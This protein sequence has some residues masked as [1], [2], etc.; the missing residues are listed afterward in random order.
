ME[1]ESGMNSQ[2]K[3][4]IV[5][6]LTSWS[7]RIDQSKLT[8]DSLL[9]QTRKLDKVYLNLDYDNFPKGMGSVPEWV[10]DYSQKGLMEVKFEAADMKVWQKIMPTIWRLNGNFK[11]TVVITAD[12]DISYP[13]TYVAEVEENMKNCDWLCTKSDEYTMG[14]YCVYGERALAALY[15][16]V[17][18]DFMKNIPLDDHGIFWIIQKYRLKRG[19]KINSVCE[20]R[21]AGYSFRRF[22]VECEDVAKLQ[23]T[24]MDYPYEEFVKE[25]QYMVKRGIVK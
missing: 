13:E 6:S 24:S 4:R 9:N 20:D 11:D 25:R 1:R 5:C 3:Y 14:Q 10:V 23:D 19:H 7:K 21:Q 16:E 8:I 12:D 17:D 18:Y 15:N 22:F 2:I